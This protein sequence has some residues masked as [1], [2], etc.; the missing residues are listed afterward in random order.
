MLAVFEFLLAALSFYISAW[1]V[2]SG[3]L[4]YARSLEGPLAPR[5]ALLGALIVTGIAATGLY[6]IQQRLRFAGVWVRLI[7]GIGFAAIGLAVIGLLL[8][9]VHR[10]ALWLFALIVASVLIAA[11]RYC[12]PLLLN[13]ELFRRRVLVYGAGRRAS[14]LLELRRRSDQRGFRIVA[15]LPA[16]GDTIRLEDERVAAADLSLVDLA[17]QLDVTEI[18]VAMD[19]RRQGFPVREL[20]ECK[21]SGINVVDLVPF[22][23][24]ETG[25]VKVELVHPGW[26]IFSEG[27]VHASKRRIVARVFDLIMSVGLLILTLPLMAAVCLAILLEDGRPLRFKQRRVGLMGKPFTLYKFRS[28]RKDAEADGGARWAQADDVRITRVGRII[29]KFRFDELPQLVNV[30]RG[31]MSFV[32]PRPERPEFVAELAEKIPYYHERHYVKPGLTGWAQLSYPY[33]ASEKDAL[34]KLQYDLYYVKNRSLIF[35]LV[36]LLQTAEVI[37]W[38]KGSR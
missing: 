8:P 32:G 9:V 3:D 10:R 11:L 2:S 33:G 15:F 36:I 18:V 25:R 24:R 30:I 37:V 19:D 23:E 13:P 35:D 34:E 26:I 14:S 17:E 38:R 1:V 6:D 20:L 27:F 29:R 31:D 7:V 12:F 21:L 28:M 4:G 16:D 22:L 5:A